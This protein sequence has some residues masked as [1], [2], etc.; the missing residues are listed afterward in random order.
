MKN[1]KYLFITLAFSILA[2]SDLEEKPIGLL[3]PEGFFKSPADIQTAVNGAIGHLQHERWWGRKMSITIMLRSDMAT[4][5]DQGTPA[6]RKDHD[7]FTVGGDNG[8]ITVF[9][10]QSYRAIAATNEAIA[11]ADQIAGSTSEEALN[12]VV[13]QAYFVR[14]F[15][16]FHLVRQFGDIPYLD[17]PV[18]DIEAAL[19]ISK[20]PAA[21]VYARIIADLE[22][23]KTWL[24]DQQPNRSLPSKGTAAAYLADVQ[25][26][27]GNFD[28]AYQEAKFVIENEGSFNFGLAADFQDLFNADKQNGLNESLFSLD[29]NGFSNGDN[30]RD[31]QGALTGIRGEQDEYG[32]GWSVAVPSI[33]VYNTW[34]GRDY[35]K[36]VSLDTVAVFKGNLEPFTKFPEFDARNLPNPYIAKYIRFP[37]L[38]QDG[39]YRASSTNYAMMRYAE[40]L[41]IA[42]EALN[43]VQPGSA[44]AA[45]YVNRVRARARN[46]AGV[47]SNFPEDVQPGLSQDEF[48]TMVLEERKWELAFE[49]KRWYD[50]ARRKLGDQVFGP[51]GLEP[52]PNFNSGR[53]Y[54]MPLPSDELV[55]NPNLEPQNPGY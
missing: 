16:Y 24:P 25:L 6:R 45:A 20:T 19:Q 13:A 50:I 10:P 33:N 7:V 2:C 27:I 22:F 34:D 18:S 14:A 46:H 32:G 53:D 23:A 9:W 5:G 51:N 42:A 38:A 37:G 3:A 31:Y 54:L 35:R 8:M 41:L 15:T 36:A 11:G 49:F 44:E 55:R 43:E 1:L 29:Y 4:I 17:E 26:T 40:V 30:G 39:N 12:A 28:Q 52:Q 21:E 48:R 47:M